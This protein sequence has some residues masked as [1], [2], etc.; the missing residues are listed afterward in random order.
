[1]VR[2]PLIGVVVQARM[3]STRLPGKVLMPIGSRPLL[4]HILRRIERLEHPARVVI[5][6]STALRDDSVARFGRDNG[7][8]VYRGSEKDVLGR[9]RHCAM[10]FSFDHV[11]RLTGDNPF[12]DVDE[13]D[14][15]IALH[16][17][18][19]ADYSSSLGSLPEGVG[20][21]IFTS[22]ALQT[23]HTHGREEHHR[24]HVNE[25]I[26][27]HPERFR[28][29]DLT[30]PVIKQRP[31]IRLTVDTPEDFRRACRIADAC[32]GSSVGTVEAIAMVAPKDWRLPKPVPGEVQGT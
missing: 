19:H 32:G 4:D 12:V 6:T 1:M 22:A 13:L 3:G 24:E 26:L 17:R 9:Y 23:S 27:E 10:A 28:I 21:E 8:E 20:A 29:M 2:Y 11:V 25:Y 7:V 14:R 15:L 16:L 31:D 5:A 18:H 30:V